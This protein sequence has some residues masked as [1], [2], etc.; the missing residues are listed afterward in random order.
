M[1]SQGGVLSSTL[2]NIYTADLAPPTALD[3]VMSYTDDITIT[4]THTSMSACQEIH[5]TIHTSRFCMD[6]KKISH[7][8]SRQNNLHSVHSRPCRIYEQSGPQNKQHCTTHGIAP[9]G[10]GSYLRCTTVC[11]KTQTYMK[12]S[13][14]PYTSTYSSTPH[15]TNRKHNIHHTPYANIQHTPRPE[16]TLFS[17]MAATQQTL[18]QTSRQSLQPTPSR[19]LIARHLYKFHTTWESRWAVS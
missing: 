2:F 16:K 8:K 6:Q 14:F 17:T 18:P 4:S 5:T 11:T 3:H 15:N 7:T 19:Y 10:Y 12:H 1:Y 9:K 13:H